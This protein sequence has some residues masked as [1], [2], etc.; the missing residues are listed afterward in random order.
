MPLNKIS[1]NPIVYAAQ[2]R[3]ARGLLNWSQG[4]LAERAGVSKQSVTR[5]ENGT[6]DP[7]FSTITALNEAIRSAGVELG[8]DSNGTVRLTVSRDKLLPPSG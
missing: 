7:R 2:I 8:D 5:I 3:A 1:R 6:M 4:E